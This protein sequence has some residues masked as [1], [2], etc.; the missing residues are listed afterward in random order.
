M[1]HKQLEFDKNNVEPELISFAEYIEQKYKPL[2]QEEYDSLEQKEKSLEDM[3]QERNIQ[4]MHTYYI[5]CVSCI[6]VSHVWDSST[7]G[8]AGRTD[9]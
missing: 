4:K 9:L 1:E 7:E 3:N 8:N 6:G 2:T 5:T